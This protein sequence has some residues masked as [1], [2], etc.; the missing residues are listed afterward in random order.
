MASVSGTPRKRR[1][2]ELEDF[3]LATGKLVAEARRARGM[4]QQEAAGQTEMDVRQW[5]K[6]E[7]GEFNLTLG[8]LLHVAQ[9][10]GVAPR[11]L[12]PPGRWA[13]KRAR[14]SADE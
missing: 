8:A 5:Q 10:L 14:P 3:K 2:R 11:D 9:L 13:P 7:A 1:P 4:T 12:V 6:M